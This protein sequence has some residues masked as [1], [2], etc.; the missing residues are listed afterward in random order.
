MT[1]SVAEAG[2]APWSPYPRKHVCAKQRWSASVKKSRLDQLLV[3]YGSVGRG[4]RVSKHIQPLGIADGSR[5]PPFFAR[6]CPSLPVR[7]L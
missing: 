3:F 1:F 2:L 7:V 6:E 5:S 4:A